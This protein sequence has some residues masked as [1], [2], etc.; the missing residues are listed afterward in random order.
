MAGT[1]TLIL[2]H[3]LMNERGKTSNL[4][5]LLCLSTVAFQINQLYKKI[6]TSVVL[7]CK[8]REQLSLFKLGKKC[9]L[10]ELMIY[11]VS[12]GSEL[13]TKGF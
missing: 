13:A 6:N 10:T 3:L 11:L 12:N 7:R 1:G 9:L 4:G 8:T 2:T 5:Q